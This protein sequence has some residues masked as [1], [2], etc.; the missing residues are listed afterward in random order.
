MPLTHPPIDAISPPFPFPASVLELP[1]ETTPPR[2]LL[3]K[4]AAGT[5]QPS[6]RPP[7]PA[8]ADPGST[9][10]NPSSAMPADIATKDFN[11]STLLRV[12][13]ALPAAL[14]PQGGKPITVRP[15]LALR[16]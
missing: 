7:T 4:S 6:K 2:P 15:W 16:P 13:A 10:V 8:E 3:L 1:N 9:T 5:L 11:M 12:V 14:T